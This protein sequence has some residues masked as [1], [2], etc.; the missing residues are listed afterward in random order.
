MTFLKTTWHHVRRS[1]YQAIAAVLIMTLTFFVISVFTFVILGSAKVISYF[2][3]RPQVTAFFK[4]EAKRENID[5][6]KEQLVATGK[7]SETRFVSKEEAL[8]IYQ[9]QNKDDP[10]LLELVTAD[11]LPASLEISTYNIEDLAVISEMLKDSTLVSEVIFQKDVVATLTSWTS[12]LR[13]IGIGLISAFS[14]V[15][16]FIMVTIIGIRISQKKEEIEI[17]RL[18]GATKWYIR[19]PFIFE[20]MMYGVAGAFF[21]WLIS[22]TILLYASPFLAAFLK[23]IPLFP[24]P[25][26]VMGEILGAELLIAIFLGMF[27]SWLAVL[28]YLK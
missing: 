27:S 18:L 3:S 21:G 26:L 1:P 9:E 20:G 7:V 23:G 10:L 5:A 28:R 2:E 24:V 13:K 17:M 16:I 14:L 8:K 12:A 4:D 6:L 25:V 19:W 15:S 22:V 11:I